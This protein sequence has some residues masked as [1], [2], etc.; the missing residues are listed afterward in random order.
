VIALVGVENQGCPVLVLAGAVPANVTA[1]HHAPTGRNF[2]SGYAAIAAY[3]A[4][5][6]G[7]S[8]AHP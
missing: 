6:Y 5:V 3:L 7:I 1:Q 4:A 8:E 2:V